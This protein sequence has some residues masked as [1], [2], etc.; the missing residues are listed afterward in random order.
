MQE[1]RGGLRSGVDIFY[2]AAILMIQ[3]Q[4]QAQERVMTVYHKA[5]SGSAAPGTLRFRF[6]V[7]MHLE[8]P[9][10]QHSTG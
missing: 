2:A 1:E 5:G 8:I 4:E 7:Y 3:E 9:A 10:F 6:T